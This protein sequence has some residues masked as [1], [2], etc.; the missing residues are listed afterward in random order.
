LS[1]PIPFADLRL[2][3]CFDA[4]V[5]PEVEL[6]GPA[7]IRQPLPLY[8]LPTGSCG[9]LWPRAGGWHVVHDGDTAHFFYVFSQ[10][11]WIPLQVAGRTAATYEVLGQSDNVH[12]IVRW[13][14][15][16][17]HLFVALL[18]TLGLLWWEQKRRPVR[19]VKAVSDSA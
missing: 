19:V 1:S 9:V 12:G 16:L 6:E 10:S 2:E 3:L 18:V 14:P 7:L 4:A 5:N 8:R 11:D 15:S 17:W 13:E